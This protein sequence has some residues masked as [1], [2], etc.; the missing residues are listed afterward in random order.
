MGNRKTTVLF[1]AGILLAALLLII[2]IFRHTVPQPQKTQTASSS[3]SAHPSGAPAPAQAAASAPAVTAADAASRLS[4]TADLLHDAKDADE[5]RRILAALKAMLSSLP[6]DV[7][8]AA[9]REFLN[10]H[11]DAATKL[12]FTISKD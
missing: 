7:A 8:S 1:S 9:I 2:A 6:P 5:A 10:T 11:K 3:P 4:V 12:D